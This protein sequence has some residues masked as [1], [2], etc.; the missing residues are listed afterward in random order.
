MIFVVVVVAVLFV[1][2]G[3]PDAACFVDVVSAFIV[4]HA[5]A[6]AVVGIMP[7]AGDPCFDFYG[8]VVAFGFAVTLFFVVA[9]TVV[10]DV[11]FFVA[12]C[13]ADD[14]DFFAVAFLVMAVECFGGDDA[15]DEAA[16]CIPAFIIC[17]GAC[18]GAKD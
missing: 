6:A 9:W 17:V 3:D 4:A 1:F 16:E 13:F 5:A 7:L 8:F 14:V 10:N 15:C 12:G 18:G 11:N 2:V